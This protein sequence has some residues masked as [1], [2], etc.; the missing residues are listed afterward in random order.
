MIK[1]KK[2][3]AF[4][5]DA[6]KLFNSMQM[7]KEDKGGA[8]TDLGQIDDVTKDLGFKMLGNSDYHNM[9]DY[10]NNVNKSKAANKR[11][12]L[13][14][15]EDVINITQGDEKKFAIHTNNMIGYIYI[16]GLDVAASDF[17]LENAGVQYH[18]QE[19]IQIIGVQLR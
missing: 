6:F 1:Y 5:G 14:D 2:T 10:F 11:I 7:L 3:E 17:Y 13:K 12:K 15:I 19:I 8:L 9:M 18:A 4:R 16:D